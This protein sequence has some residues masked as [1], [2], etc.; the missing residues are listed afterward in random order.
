MAK[1]LQNWMIEEAVEYAKDEDFSDDDIELMI[2]EN[3]NCKG[4]C[5]YEC[6]QDYDDQIAILTEALRLRI[7]DGN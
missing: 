1:D 3:S 2:T 4:N 6:D 7:S 5:C